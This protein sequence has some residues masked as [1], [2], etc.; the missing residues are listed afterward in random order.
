MW[1]TSSA[2]VFA[3]TPLALELEVV[4]ADAKRMLSRE[5]LQP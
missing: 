5:A 1:W 2:E 4:I 3:F